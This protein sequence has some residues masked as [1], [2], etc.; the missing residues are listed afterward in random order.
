MRFLRFLLLLMVLPLAACA[1]NTA[2]GTYPVD[3]QGP[4]TLDTGDV[5]RIMVYGDDALGDDYAV[6]DAGKIAFPLIGPTSVRGLTTEAAAARIASKLAA[7]YIRSPDVSMEIATYRPFFIQG[8]VGQSG[9]YP[10]VYGMTARAAIST[11]GGFKETADRTKV[12]VYRPHNGQMIK[13]TV[14]LDFPIQ[15]GDTIVVLDRWI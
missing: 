2:P 14:G 5:V 10:F 7:G 3:Q 11:A 6:D 9:Q 15:P 4:Y 8:E 1:G 12:V 13:G